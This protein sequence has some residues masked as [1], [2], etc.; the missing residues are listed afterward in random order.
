MCPDWTPGSKG[1][2]WAPGLPGRWERA[3]PSPETPPAPQGHTPHPVQVSRRQETLRGPAVCR[4]SRSVPGW[5]RGGHLP[6]TRRDSRGQTPPPPAPGTLLTTELRQAGSQAGRGHGA[7]QAHG[8]TEAGR[9]GSGQTRAGTGAQSLRARAS[10][11]R[12]RCQG[13]GT[14]TGYSLAWAQ[15]CD[16]S[17]QAATRAGDVLAGPE[18]A[19]R[20]SPALRRGC[21]GCPAPQVHPPKPAPRDG[22]WLPLEMGSVK[23]GSG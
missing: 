22:D 2:G 3:L 12:G 9:T 23:R 6:V 17:G 20:G 13:W 16:E 19:I 11:G 5:G 7:C 10:W 14:W 21:W 4:P 15:L 1:G 18:G 8:R